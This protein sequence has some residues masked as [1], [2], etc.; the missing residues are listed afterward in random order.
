MPKNKFRTRVVTRTEPE[1]CVMRHSMQIF[2]LQRTIVGLH[3]HVL[4]TGR[5]WNMKEQAWRRA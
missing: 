5:L 4:R 1:S 3:H 2:Q